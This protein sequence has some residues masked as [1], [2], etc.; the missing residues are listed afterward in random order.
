LQADVESTTSSLPITSFGQQD[1][2]QHKMQAMD[3]ELSQTLQ[4]IAVSFATV[5]LECPPG[6]L[7]LSDMNIIRSTLGEFSIFISAYLLNYC[8]SK[9]RH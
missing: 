9:W 2:D 7:L 5:A 4:V 8:R 1:L 6:M 3:S